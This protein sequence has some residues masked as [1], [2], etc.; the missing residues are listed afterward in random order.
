MAKNDDN[1]IETCTTVPFGVLRKRPEGA[2]DNTTTTSISMILC[3]TKSFIGKEN[4]S[5]LTAKKRCFS[6]EIIYGTDSYITLLTRI[7]LLRAHK[8]RD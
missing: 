3:E 5:H 2:S 7:M 6:S 1:D 4:E 8:K